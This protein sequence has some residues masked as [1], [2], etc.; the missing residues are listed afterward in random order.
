MKKDVGDFYVGCDIT[1]KKV[2]VLAERELVG[3]L[4][5]IK[6]NQLDMIYS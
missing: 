6:M 1:L 2:K 3:R 5:Y 4:E